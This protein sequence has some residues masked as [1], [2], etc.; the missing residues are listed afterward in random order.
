VE[1]IFFESPEQWRSWLAEHHDAGSEVL[2]GFHKVGTGRPSIT[3]SQSVDEALCFGWIDGVRR[4]VDGD[5]YSI[6]FTPRKPG[7]HWSRVNVLK[8]AELT[9]AGRMLPPGLAAFQARSEERTAQT[10]YER[11]EPAALEA[12]AQ[13][14]FEADPAAWQWF[15]SAPPSYR[16]VALHWVVS[17]K[18]EQTR[19]RRLGIL[20]ECSREGRRIPSQA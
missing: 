8:V 6:R 10:A 15:R 9:A 11:T 4:R 1:P 16:R 12:E 3:W 19:Q 7:S 17:A 2:V 13:A 18:R 5:S 20:I 14:R